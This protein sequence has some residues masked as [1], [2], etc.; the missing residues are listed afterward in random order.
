MTQQQSSLERRISDLEDSYSTLKS[1]EYLKEF[2]FKRWDELNCEHY[3]KLN[4]QGEQLA[5]LKEKLTQLE[6]KVRN[7]LYYQHKQIELMTSLMKIALETSH[8]NKQNFEIFESKVKSFMSCSDLRDS[9]NKRGV[10]R[11]SLEGELRKINDSLQ[12]S[13]EEENNAVF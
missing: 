7:K 3:V 1:L 8:T 10:T 2:D 13:E 6:E 9:M 12:H 5:E 4:K 11:E